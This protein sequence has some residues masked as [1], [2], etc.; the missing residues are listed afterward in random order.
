MLEASGTGTTFT[1]GDLSNTSGFSFT[2]VSHSFSAA[3]LSILNNLKNQL[4]A[5]LSFL[6]NYGKT[7]NNTTQAEFTE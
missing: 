1:S 5:I 6:N 4:L 7:P 3:T 2:P